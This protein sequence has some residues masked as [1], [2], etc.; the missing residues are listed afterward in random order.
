MFS[1][2]QPCARK[3]EPYGDSAGFYEH[4]PIRRSTRC[5]CERGKAVLTAAMRTDRPDR[6]HVRRSRRGARVIATAHKKIKDL[7][8]DATKVRGRV[9][10]SSRKGLY[11]RQSSSISPAAIGYSR[12]VVAL[13]RASPVC[14]NLVESGRCSARLHA[15]CRDRTQM[16]ACA[17]C[18][19]SQNISQMSAGRP[20]KEKSNF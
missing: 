2:A 8:A 15:A 12:P 9:H 14:P 19:T 18:L 16:S 17:A 11:S 1:K 5:T 7:R 6:G 13:Q 10:Q 4:P 3:I 20:N